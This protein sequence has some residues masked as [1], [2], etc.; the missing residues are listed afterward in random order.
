MPT[1]R[2]AHV[3]SA[4]LPFGME[5]AHE[6]GRSSGSCGPAAQT[7]PLTITLNWYRGTTMTSEVFIAGAAMTAF[8]R[9]HDRSMQ[10]LAQAA[11]S[12]ALKDAGLTK[13]DIDAIY[14]SNVYGG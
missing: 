9:H 11:V 14:A 7:P 2:R 10:D 13:H 5:N 6:S 3:S 8:G 4:D 12:D 1:F